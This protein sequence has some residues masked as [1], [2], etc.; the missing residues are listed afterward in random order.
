MKR[1]NARGRTPSLGTWVRL[2]CQADYVGPRLPLWEDEKMKG[3]LVLFLFYQQN[4]VSICFPKKAFSSNIPCDRGENVLN[5][6]KD[7]VTQIMASKEI[8]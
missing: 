6:D 8:T 5:C 7:I 1:K 2:V 3:E 4:L